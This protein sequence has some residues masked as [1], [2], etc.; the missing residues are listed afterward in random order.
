MLEFSV[1]GRLALFTDPI[2]GLGGEKYSYHIPTYEALRGIT[3]NI[4]WKPTFNWIIDKVRVMKPIRTFNKG[5]KT[6]SYYTGKHDLSYYTYLREVE[7]QVVAHIEWNMLR[8]DLVADR[9]P[10][11]H[12]A[13]ACRSLDKGGRKNIV[14]GV[15]ECPGDVEPCKFGEGQGAYDNID[16]MGYGLMFHGFDYPELTGKTDINGNPDINGEERLFARFWRPVMKNGVIEFKRPDEI[17]DKKFIR[18]MKSVNPAT[19]GVDGDIEVEK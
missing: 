7:Y 2:T 12:H 18:L 14:L 11:K 17:K 9:Q 10:G 5:I 16:E 8:T 13:I 19:C 6:L 3:Q 15:T 4:Y 1:K